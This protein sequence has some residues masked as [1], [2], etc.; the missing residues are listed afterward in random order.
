[1]I[2]LT[3]AAQPLR[4]RCLKLHRRAPTPHLHLSDPHH[5][6]RRRPPPPPPPPSLLEVWQRPTPSRRRLALSRN[7]PRQRQYSSRLKRRSCR[8]IG[9]D[10]TTAAHP[11]QV[12]APVSHAT[13][14]GVMRGSE[15][16][17]AQ[18]RAARVA[19][20]LR[21][22][23]GAHWTNETAPES[24]RSSTSARPRSQRRSL[25]LLRCG[26]S[27]IAHLTFRLLTIG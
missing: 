5:R 9:V 16:A 13:R 4:P 20:R 6:R 19:Q 12:Q 26:D 22:W 24:C 18:P 21:W 17:A 27:P 11:T 25:R 1:M 8:S 15:S 2:T 14:A 7:P 10:S 23:R 3:A